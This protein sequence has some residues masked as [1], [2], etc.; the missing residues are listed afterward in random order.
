MGGL[1]K[2]AC[3]MSKPYITAARDN[4]TQLSLFGPSLPHVFGGS[5]LHAQLSKTSSLFLRPWEWQEVVWATR[6]EGGVMSRHRREWC[7]NGEFDPRGLNNMAFGRK[8]KKVKGLGSA[9]AHVATP[10]RVNIANVPL[11]TSLDVCQMPIQIFLMLNGIFFLAVKNPVDT[12]W[13]GS[14]LSI[15]NFVS[16]TLWIKI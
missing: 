15:L 9:C 8:E 7:A 16:C 2:R 14:D 1:V 10:G 4:V 5:L 3:L 6:W 13:K 11:G 12:N